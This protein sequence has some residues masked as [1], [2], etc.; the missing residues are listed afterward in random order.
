MSVPSA[1]DCQPVRKSF[2]KQDNARQNFGIKRKELGIENWKLRIRNF[3]RRHGLGKQEVGISTSLDYH[4]FAR[5]PRLR[6]TTSWK[7]SLSK[8]RFHSRI[9]WTLSPSKYRCSGRFDCAQRPRLRS[10]S[11]TT[12]NDYEFTRWPM[13][14]A[15]PFWTVFP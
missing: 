7:L 10:T 4:Y 11:T 12:L 6:S 2:K 3:K 5:L 14:L 9:K 1:F 15:M 13:V 8:C